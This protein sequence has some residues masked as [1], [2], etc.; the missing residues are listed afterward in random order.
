MVEMSGF[1]RQALGHWT[2]EVAKRLCR[3][4]IGGPLNLMSP[5]HHGVP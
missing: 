5:W 1:F 2:G 3:T 4:K